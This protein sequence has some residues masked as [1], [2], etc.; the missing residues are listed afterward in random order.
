MYKKIYKKCIKCIKKFIKKCI[1]C[2]KT[3]YIGPSGPKI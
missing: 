2:I 1:K 3:M